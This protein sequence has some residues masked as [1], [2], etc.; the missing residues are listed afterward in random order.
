MGDLRLLRRLMHHL[1]KDWQQF[2]LLMF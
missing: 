2:L 1:L